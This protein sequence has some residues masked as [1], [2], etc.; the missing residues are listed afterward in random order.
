MSEQLSYGTIGRE[1]TAAIVEAYAML[2]SCLLVSLQDEVA[3][4][5]ATVSRVV[6]WAVD[7]GMLNSGLKRGPGRPA[8]SIERVIEIDNKYPGATRKEQAKLVGVD[9]STFLRILPAE[10]KDR[11]NKNKE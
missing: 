3:A 11:Q 8:T 2:Q 9:Q 1:Q 7:V 5:S 4:G 6:N 10:R